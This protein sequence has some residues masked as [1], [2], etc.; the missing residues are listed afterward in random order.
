MAGQFGIGLVKPSLP[1]RVP[2]LFFGFRYRPNGTRVKFTSSQG[3][4]AFALRPFPSF[5]FGLAYGLPLP[6][7][8]I[9]CEGRSLTGLRDETGLLN[10]VPALRP[11][12]T[13]L[14][15]NP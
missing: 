14:H 7:R 15:S 12:S 11:G 5:I 13:L 8:L 2:P 10:T 9:F 1:L 3:R 6:Y 4:L